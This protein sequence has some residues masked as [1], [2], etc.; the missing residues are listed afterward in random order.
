[1]NVSAWCNCRKRRKKRKTEKKSSFV[2]AFSE[3]TNEIIAAMERLVF[4]EGGCNINELL[5]KSSEYY[6]EIT[7]D[8]ESRKECYKNGFVPRKRIAR[9]AARRW[10]RW[11]C[12]TR[13]LW[14]RRKETT[15][16]PKTNKTIYLLPTTYSSVSCRR[17]LWLKKDVEWWD[18]EKK[19]T[20]LL[21]FFTD[22]MKTMGHN[23]Y[24]ANEKEETSKKIK[25]LRTEKEKLRA[26]NERLTKLSTRWQRRRLLKT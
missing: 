24:Y 26:E 16:N 23:E 7:Q 22:L 19:T 20:I 10:D 1:M 15:Q 14:S 12:K 5:Q 6:Q 18:M 21:T 13:R 8:E 3:K 9:F 2:N 4:T 11:T 25:Q 17:E